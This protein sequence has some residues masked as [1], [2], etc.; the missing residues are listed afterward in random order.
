MR[1]RQ[2]NSQRASGVWYLQD[3]QTGEQASLRTRDKT[4]ATRLLNA[5]NEAIYQPAAINLQLARAYISA[6]DPKL[7]T[8][9]WQEVMET[10]VSLKREESHRR[11]A[12]AVVVGAGGGPRPARG[13]SAQR[14]PACRA[15]GPAHDR[16]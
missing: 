6:S 15:R 5:K 10:V 13:R 16:G 14:C 11:W 1:L 8:R 7:G 4:A 3:R 12:V 2:S 9:T